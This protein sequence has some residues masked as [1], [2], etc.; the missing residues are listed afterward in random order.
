MA[1]GV[2]STSK[3]DGPPPA[4]SSFGTLKRENTFRH[5]S[6]QATE[7]PAIH[8]LIAPHVTSFN[9]LFDGPD[10]I[11]D[12]PS[13]V[14]FDSERQAGEHRDSRNRLEFKI[15]E[16]MV[17]NPL[18]MEKGQGALRDRIYPTEARER[19]THMLVRFLLRL[20]GHSTTVH[21]RMN[22]GISVCF[23]SWLNQRNVTSK[24]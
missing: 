23:R 18:A 13:K 5:P 16:L 2:P 11:A 8:E 21:L 14:V 6:T 3:L 17:S 10:A 19:L 15:T 24:G 9:A 1:T 20:H 7:N 22:I 12:L 4:S